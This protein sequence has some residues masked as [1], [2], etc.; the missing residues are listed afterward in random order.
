MRWPA[1]LSNVNH[2]NRSTMTWNFLFSGHDYLAMN[3]FNCRAVV[4]TYFPTGVAIVILV[5]IAQGVLLRVLLLDLL[6]SHPFA[7]SLQ[8]KI[9]TGSIHNSSNNQQ[10]YV[11]SF[12]AFVIERR[13]TNISSIIIIIIWRCYSSVNALVHWIY[14][15]KK[16]RKIQIN[17]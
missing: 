2:S 11:F 15:T 3:Q 7:D 6:V 8:G 12:A 14:T 13:I 10:L 5:G 4:E 9:F 1:T 16:S 17:K